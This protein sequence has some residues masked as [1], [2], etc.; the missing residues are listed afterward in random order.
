[1]TATRT[2][3]I[4]RALPRREDARILAG[5]S[6]YLDD[7]DEPDGLLHAAF[8]RSPFARAEIRGVSVPR[9]ARSSSPRLTSPASFP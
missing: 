4:G 5:A 3:W 2:G 6:R 7:L 8:V 1:M 9:R